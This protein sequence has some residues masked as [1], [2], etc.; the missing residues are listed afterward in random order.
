MEAERLITESAHRYVSAYDIATI[1]AVLKDDDRAL[2]WLERA[3]EERSQLIG[4]LP[5]DGVFDGIRQDPRYL[6]LL[7]RLNVRKHD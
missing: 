6:E 7:Q 3:F 4:W 2:L 1:F 5:W